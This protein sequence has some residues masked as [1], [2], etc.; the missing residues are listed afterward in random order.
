[1]NFQMFDLISLRLTRLL[2]IAGLAPLGLA[3][4]ATGNHT[5]AQFA[6]TE[7]GAA[8]L[9][10]PIKVPSGIGGM[11]PQLALNYSSGVGNGL[12]GLGWTLSGPSGRGQ[13]ALP[14]SSKAQGFRLQ[15]VDYKKN[16]VGYPA[17]TCVLTGL[18]VV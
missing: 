2:C 11:E 10:V 14:M 5:G 1:M 9:S 6:V 8:T 15:R 3:A 18:H 17:G 7:S 12:F 13:T 4:H 16:A